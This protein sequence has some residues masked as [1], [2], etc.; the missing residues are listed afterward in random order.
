MFRL[1]LYPVLFNENPNRYI[2]FYLQIA[3]KIQFFMKVTFQNLYLYWDMQ[4]LSEG[5]VF[6]ISFVN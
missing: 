4:L 2:V 5:Y 6:S 1:K 3:L